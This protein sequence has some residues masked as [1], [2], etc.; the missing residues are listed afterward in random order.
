MSQIK[1]LQSADCASVF[2]LLKQVYEAPPYPL[3]GAWTMR[4]VETELEKGK[5]FGLFEEGQLQALVLFR[6]QD[7]IWDIVML[8]TLPDRQRRGDMTRLLQE[9]AGRR[10]PNVELW[11]E[12]HEANLAAHNLYK[13]LGFRQVGRR[14]GYYRDGCA[15]VLYSLR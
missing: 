2:N 5:G 15:A 14:P 11:L 9:V 4:L 13:K 6:H 1:S 3:G 7:L 8:A 10:P 12:V